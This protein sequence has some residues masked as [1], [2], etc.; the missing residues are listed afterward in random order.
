MA[1]ILSTAN[2]VKSYEETKDEG[3]DC[4]E[5]GQTIFKTKHYKEI[6]V[7]EKGAIRILRVQAGSPDQV[8]VICELVATTIAERESSVGNKV[9]QGPTNVGHADA[10]VKKLDTIPYDA[11]SWCWGK[12]PSKSEIKIKKGRHQ[13][14]KYVQ[15]GLVAALV[16]LRHKTHD[17][18]LW[19]DAVCINQ[20]DT[21]EKNVSGKRP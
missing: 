8:D 21:A 14:V 1:D 13:Y 10:E 20:M 17:V 19:V 16:A 9:A 11:L 4:T 5:Q 7:T 18:D 3:P 15:P 6:P 12:V 2:A